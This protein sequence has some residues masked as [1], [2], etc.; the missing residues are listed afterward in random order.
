MTEQPPVEPHPSERWDLAAL[1][2]RDRDEQWRDVVSATHLPWTLDVHREPPPVLRGR[3]LRRRL[4]DVH[5][6]ETWCDPCGGQRLRS[7]IRRTDGEYVG[8]LVVRAGHEVLTYGD[9]QLALGPGDVVAWRSSER[10]RFDVLEPLRKHTL[11]VPVARYQEVVSSTELTT[12]RLLRPTSA[13]ALFISYLDM[14]TGLDLTSEAAASAGNAALELLGATVATLGSPPGRE[15]RR[16]ELRQRVKGYVEAHLDDPTLSARTIARQH[17]VSERL[18]YSLFEEEG[19]TVRAF[20][21]RRRL[22]RA[23]ADL[24][25]SGGALAVNRVARRWGF[26]DP[27][28]FSRAFRAHYGYSPSEACGRADSGQGPAGTGMGERPPRS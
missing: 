22:A 9:E 17:A 14:V 13:R 7:D 8:V 24:T 15:A 25:R 4:G 12:A 26:S 27:A 11:L 1:P 3:V 21:R 19:D 6:L 16:H 23:H 18:L 20:V 2:A 10:I 28:H 5:L